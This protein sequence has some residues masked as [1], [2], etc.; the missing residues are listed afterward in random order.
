MAAPT[1]VASEVEETLK[2][3][4]SHK[5]VKGVIIMNSAGVSI[6]SNMP[7]EDTENY[8]AIVS[9]LAIKAAG[10]VRS[11]DPADELTFLRIRSRKHEIMVAPDAD[12]VLVVVQDPAES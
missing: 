2:R 6:R 4:S 9:Q 7:A 1:G 5:G 8:A 3:I 11:L 10:A 12:Y